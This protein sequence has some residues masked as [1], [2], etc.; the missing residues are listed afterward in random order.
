MLTEAP[1]FTS[2]LRLDI[3]G[4]TLEVFACPTQEWQLHFTDEDG[5]GKH[6]TIMTPTPQDAMKLISALASYARA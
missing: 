6:T 1:V 2:V 5:H 4:D 3:Y